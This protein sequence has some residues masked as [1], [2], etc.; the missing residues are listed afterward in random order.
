MSESS[1][2][3]DRNAAPHTVPPDE[4]LPRKSASPLLWVLVLL[5]LLAV[6]FYFMTRRDTVVPP[7]V[8]ATPIGETSD[9]APVETAPPTATAARREAPTQ[10][11]QPAAA[12][13]RDARP[14]QQPAPEYPVAAMRAGDEGTVLVRAEID[15]SGKPSNVE[16]AK[17]SR[18]RD[19]DR[20]ALAAV[21]NWTFEPAIR[22]GKAVASTVQ[23]PVDFRL[24]RQ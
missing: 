10:R 18:S 11:R 7:P 12:R 24:D 1:N 17:R 16:L 22:D 21:R 13:N 6:L 4:A 9:A 3:P 5:A 8:P 19:L 20:A 2:H 23:V 15:A 14:L